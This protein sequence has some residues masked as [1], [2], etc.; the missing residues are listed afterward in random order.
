M[1]QT[2]LFYTDH[3]DMKGSGPAHS[4]LYAGLLLLSRHITLI[5]KSEISFSISTNVGL[6]AFSVTDDNLSARMI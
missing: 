2:Q 6:G 1:L 5:S 4:M 3:I